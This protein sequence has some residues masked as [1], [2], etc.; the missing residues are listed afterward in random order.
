MTPSSKNGCLYS[1]AMQRTI[2]LGNIRWLFVTFTLGCLQ[3]VSTTASLAQESVPAITADQ[4]QFFESKIRP[5]LAEACGDCHGGT[6]AESGLRVDS[7]AALLAGGDSGPAITL[8]DGATSLLLKVVNY[9]GDIRMPPDQKL[10]DDEIAALRKWIEEGAPWPNSG[11][12]TP[13]NPLGL[14]SGPI[15]DAD[16][17]HWAFQP[18]AKPSVPMHDLSNQWARTDIDRFLLDAMT[19][20]N[21]QPGSDVDRRTWLRR[22]T[23]DLIGLPPTIHE[24]EAFLNNSSPDADVEAIDRLLQS[25]HFG[26]R[27][28][29]HW[30]DV[31]R[32]A[33]TAG[34]GADYPIREA[35]KYRDYV[36]AAFN[37]DKPYNRFLQEQIAGDILANQA[38]AAGRITTEEYANQITATGYL[39]MTKRFGYNINNEFQH[40]DIADTLDNFGQSIL[41]LSIGCARCHDHKYDAIT[42]EDYYAL[43]GIFAS[44]QYSFPG[45]EEFKKPHNLIPLELPSVVNSARQRVADQV[46]VLAA[47]LAEIEGR[48]A[49]LIARNMVGLSRDPGLEMQTLNQPGAAPWFTA[50]PN[51]VIPEAQSP[52]AHVLPIGSQ[53]I[54][55]SHGK[56]TDGVRQEFSDVSAATSSL[57]HFNFDFRNTE[58]VEG[59]GGYRFFLARG[60][61]QSLAIQVSVDSRQIKVSN[62]ERT[63]VVRGLDPGVWY[64]V[65][66]QIDLSKRTFS[67]QIGRPGD[68]TSFE[69][70]A[71][72]PNWDGILNTFVCDGFGDDQS[73]SPTRD[74]DNVIAQMNPFPPLSEASSIQPVSTQPLVDF[75]A[76][77]DEL[78][79]LDANSGR[80]KA[81][82]TALQS[83]IGFPMAY[84][85]V[86]GTP[87]NAK[88][89]RRGEPDRLGDEVPR[90][91]LEILGGDLVPDDY[92]GSGRLQLAQWVSRDSNPLT[93]RVIVNRV[94]H[95]LFGRGLVDT[96]NDFGTRGTRPSHPELLDFLAAEFAEDGWSIKRLIRRIAMSRAYRLTSQTTPQQLAVDAQNLWFARHRRRPLDAESIRDSILA[97]SGGL[98]T[99]SAGP[100]PFPKVD[101]WQFTIHY[102]FHAVYDSNR[103]SVYLMIQR[104]RRHPFLA[105]F[106]AADPNIST[107]TRQVTITPTQSLYLMNAPLVH[108]RAEQLASRISA[109]CE[110]AD[111]D[112]DQAV[113]AAYETVL[114]RHPDES[115][116]AQA[117]NFLNRSRKIL[118]STGDEGAWHQSIA[119]FCRVLLTSNEFLYVD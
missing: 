4:E 74:I 28:G 16:R 115:E 102:P 2:L 64:N 105:L 106:D 34:D 23:Y 40:L 59:P 90:R 8:A 45:G 84:G 12:E 15:T 18:V 96:P 56:L 95:H 37:S 51:S 83:S 82:Q 27:W 35:Y 32:Y 10:A 79:E 39:A 46:G 21:I 19:R 13:A 50:G 29:R 118:R 89:Q 103:R 44:S 104:A 113:V 43:Y 75:V 20:H 110:P 112:A 67:G 108:Q 60:A 57:L 99:S 54:R 49:E 69:D 86:E 63:Q 109:S 58:A 9:D 38:A 76:I 52:F 92:H 36:I 119:A 11:D 72:H 70:F 5:L 33:D 117:T 91:F 61:L 1:R 17:Q 62:G 97:V 98:D 71:I 73:K 66:F 111:T 30:L 114:A 100:H 80:I 31:V 85:V 24:V 116:I 77:K 65:Q 101:S 26:E 22:L 14:R 68:V 42:A 88:V 7:R 107:A 53:G 25:P 78:K 6:K 87:L 3:I 41:G 94:W 93:A 48:R 55:I 81:E 47:R